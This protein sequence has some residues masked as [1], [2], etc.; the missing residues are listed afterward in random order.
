MSEC[1]EYVK[2]Y[3]IKSNE[4]CVKVCEYKKKYGHDPHQYGDDEEQKLAYWLARR[5]QAFRN[6]KIIKFY[7]SDLLIAQRYGYY[8][9]FNIDREAHSNDMCRKLCAYLVAHKKLP[10][11]CSKNP[12]EKKLGLWLSQKK[13]SLR[14][15][16][17]VK[18]YDSD[19]KIAEE[20]GFP[21]L[22]VV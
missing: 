16:N 2:S 12:D 7:E 8:E 3:E 17:L 9:L 11:T 20:F 15:M 22:F 13:Q 19:R 6:P 21:D 4:T 18:F 14:G 5:R 10:S 1:K